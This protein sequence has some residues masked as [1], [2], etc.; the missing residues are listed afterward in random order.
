[1]LETFFN[2]VVHLSLRSMSFISLS[3]DLHDTVFYIMFYSLVEVG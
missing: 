3:F 1:M 2:N